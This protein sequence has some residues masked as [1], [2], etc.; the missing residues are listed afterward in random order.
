[1]SS[2]TRTDIGP[3]MSQVVSHGD[4]LYLA[5][6][7]AADFSADIKEQ[8][9]SVLAK[10]DALLAPA[11]SSKENLLSV[12]IYIRDMKDFAAMNEIWDGW[13]PQGQTPARACVQAPMALPDILVEMSVIAA[14]R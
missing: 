8:T 2:I 14:K 7:V 1:M 5:G 10:I 3:R 13:V 6:Q 4:T 9:R 11:G 12:T